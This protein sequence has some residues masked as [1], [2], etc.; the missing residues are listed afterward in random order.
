MRSFIIA[1]LFSAAPVAQAPNILVFVADDAGWDDFGCYGNEVVRTPNIDAL[2]AE[3]MLVERAFL[4]IAQCSPSRISI[5][6]GRYP[7]ATG[8]EDLHTPLPDDQVLVT[9]HLQDRGY[10]TGIQRKKHL[11]PAGVRQFDWQSNDLVA[12]FPRFLEAFSPRGS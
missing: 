7:H 9:R 10:F 4:T 3:G 11:G 12:G 6:T 5:L 2:A 1:L 8:A